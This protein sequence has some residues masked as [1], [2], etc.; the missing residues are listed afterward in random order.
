MFS[1]NFKENNLDNSELLQEEI[2]NS[3]Q[4]YDKPETFLKMV[5]T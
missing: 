4:K 5:Y 3:Y 1:K 2:P